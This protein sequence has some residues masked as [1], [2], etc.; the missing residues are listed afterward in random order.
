[1]VARFTRSIPGQASGQ[2]G[3]VQRRRPHADLGQTRQILI[4]GV[5]DPL[6][7]AEHLGDGPQRGQRVTAVADRVD[8]H[9]AG[10]GPPDLNQ[11]GPVGVAETRRPLGVHREW[12]VPAIQECG[13]RLDLADGHREIRDPVGRVE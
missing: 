6:V 8:E 11:V 1:M 3:V 2:L 13:G 10:A 7:R 12:S 4:G 5:Q 9:G